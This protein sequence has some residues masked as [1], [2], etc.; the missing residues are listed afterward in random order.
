MATKLCNT[1]SPTNASG[2]THL[3]LR[4]IKY[5]ASM[6]I[7]CEISVISLAFILSSVEDIMSIL[8]SVLS[9]KIHGDAFVVCVDI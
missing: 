1:Y 3:K 7:T 9:G 4:H 6:L 5:C 8:S 2:S